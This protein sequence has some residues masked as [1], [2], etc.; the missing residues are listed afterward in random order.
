MPRQRRYRPPSATALLVLLALI[1]GAFATSGVVLFILEH[2]RLS[3]EVDRVD[4]L[5]RALARV[6]A[7]Q[8]GELERIT[9]TRRQAVLVICHDTNALKVELRLVLRRFGVQASELPLNPATGRRAFAPKHCSVQA[10]RLVPDPRRATPPWVPE[11]ERRGARA[12]H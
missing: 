7:S 2:V 4:E 9:T 1:A 6:Q 3:R 10:L 12:G 11:L 8:A 5:T